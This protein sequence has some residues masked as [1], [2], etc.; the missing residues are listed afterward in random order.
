MRIRDLGGLGAVCVVVGILMGL[1]VN[2]SAQGPGGGPM[3]PRGPQGPPPGAGGGLPPVFLRVEL[4]DQ[5][6]TEIKVLVDE[7]REARRAELEERRTLHLQLTTAIYGTTTTE[8]ETVAQIVTRLGELQKLALDADVTLQTKIAALLT[9]QQRQQIVEQDRALTRASWPR[10]AEAQAFKGS[11]VQ[12][13]PCP[14]EPPGPLNPCPLTRGEAVE[15][16]VAAGALQVGL[17]AAARGVRGV[18]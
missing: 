17:T 9:D 13:R 14:V 16:P 6:R 3:D 11:K 2:V 10:G 4:T 1:A 15:E 18:P 5:Q 7:Q 12:G 8:A